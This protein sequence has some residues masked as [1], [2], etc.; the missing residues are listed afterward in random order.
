MFLNRLGLK[1]DMVHDWVISVQHGIKS[2]YKV[3]IIEETRTPTLKEE[4]F[5]KSCWKAYQNYLPISVEFNKFK[6]VI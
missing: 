3:I 2:V 5:Y 1:E 6:Y 4:H